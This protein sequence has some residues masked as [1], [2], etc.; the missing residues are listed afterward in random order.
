MVEIPLFTA[1]TEPPALALAV[2]VT[3]ALLRERRAWRDHRAPLAGFFAVNAVFDA[4]NFFS[5]AIPSPAT[6]WLVGLAFPLGFLLGPLIFGYVLML[7]EGAARVRGFRRHLWAV[8]VAYAL[9]TPFFLLSGAE[10]TAFV[11]GVLHK[12]S[13]LFRVAGLISVALTIAF[14]VHALAY[15]AACFRLLLRHE[16][17]LRDLFSNIEDKTLGWLRTLLLALSVL[18]LFTLGDLIFLF[19]PG[20]TGE[21]LRAV[22]DIVS[23]L[24]EPAWIFALGLLGLRQGAAVVAPAAP[25]PSAPRGTLADEDA[26]RILT[27]L[28]AV[29]REDRLFLR[30]TLTLHD[31]GQAPR[32]S[33]HHLSEALNHRRGV[34]FYDFVNRLRVEAAAEILRT[35][36]DATALDA[37]IAV[38][39]N[40]RS[41]FNA[42]FKKVP[43]ATPSGYRARLRPR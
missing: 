39:F 11:G 23:G 3:C 7:T 16:L 8:P 15:L 9:L 42:A 31:V 27:R 22:L 32:A 4:V 20:P 17:R 5:A 25:S 6:S 18:W 43:G 13:T 28:D 33:D 24:A 35:D 29:M 1:L 37:M 36:S 41:T 38:G 34:K 2:F 12:P 19:A 40:A 26:D 10:K 30:P 14:I 21:R